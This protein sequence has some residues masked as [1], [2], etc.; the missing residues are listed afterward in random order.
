MSLR[1]AKTCKEVEHHKAV[2]IS[3]ALCQLPSLKSLD[4]SDFF[5]QKFQTNQENISKFQ[6]QKMEVQ[7]R[8]MIYWK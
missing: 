8:C 1:I 4:F 2:R 5:P 6:L 3:M 7:A